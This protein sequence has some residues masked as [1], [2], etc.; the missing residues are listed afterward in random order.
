[1]SFLEGN[2]FSE[3]NMVSVPNP[4]VYQTLQSTIGKYVVIETV[5]GKLKDAKPDHLLIEYTV[6]YI[7]RIQK[8]V[9]V[10]PKQ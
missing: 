6:P 1:M 3:Q 2:D 8:I 10:M 7:V 9:W 5:R 4:Y